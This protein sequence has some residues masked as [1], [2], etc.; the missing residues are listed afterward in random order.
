M[1][2]VLRFPRCFSY[3]YISGLNVSKTYRVCS[4][5]FQLSQ[6]AKSTTESGLTPV[7]TTPTRNFPASCSSCI[8]GSCHPN[9]SPNCLW[10]CIFFSL[11]SIDHRSNGNAMTKLTLKYS[12]A[13]ISCW[14]DNVD[15]SNNTWTLCFCERTDASRQFSIPV[16]EHC[17]YSYKCQLICSW[18]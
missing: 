10:I 6:R 18:A 9:V 8:S 17:F 7:P 15:R 11:T 2:T 5:L 4:L 1:S 14:V 3:S 12:F 13:V 16:S